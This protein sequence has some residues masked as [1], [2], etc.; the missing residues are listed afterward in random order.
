MKFGEGVVPS[1]Q[2]PNEHTI[3]ISF[4]F[5]NKLREKEEKKRK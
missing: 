3:G 1:S 2:S 5:I 4:E